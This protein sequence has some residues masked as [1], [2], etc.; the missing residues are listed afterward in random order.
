MGLGIGPRLGG[1]LVNGGCSDLTAMAL[2]AGSIRN[3]H[4]W[5]QG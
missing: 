4:A 2:V 5:G 3:G 1:D